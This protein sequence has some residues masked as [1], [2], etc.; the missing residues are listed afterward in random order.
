MKLQI[1]LGFKGFLRIWIYKFSWALNNAG[2]GSTDPPRSQKSACNLTVHIP[3]WASVSTSAGSTNQGPSGPKA[4]HLLKTMCQRI[5]ADQNRVIQGPSVISKWQSDYT[6]SQVL[7]LAWITGIPAKICCKSHV[8]SSF[9]THVSGP[10]VLAC[11]WICSAWAEQLSPR[12]PTSLTLW[13]V[14][15]YSCLPVGSCWN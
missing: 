7:R 11:L 14:H 15:R 2:I 9:T 8:L 6:Y 10:C 3:I 13:S 5:Q 1:S 12:A 4:M